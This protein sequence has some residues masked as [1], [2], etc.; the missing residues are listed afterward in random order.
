M[1]IPV[2][3]DNY[4]CIFIHVLIFNV[5]TKWRLV[6]QISTPVC[7][8]DLVNNIFDLTVILV[9]R[10]WQLCI[11]CLFNELVIVCLFVPTAFFSVPYD[12]RACTNT[13]IR[14]TIISAFSHQWE[15]DEEP[16]Y[17]VKAAPVCS[18]GCTGNQHLPFREGQQSL[19]S[20]SMPCFSVCLINFTCWPFFSSVFFFSTSVI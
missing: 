4:N 7:N 11:L 10:H 1:F 20:L 14:M 17:P 19:Q 2:Q 6:H 15:K 18:P 13:G 12:N 16:L 5:D 9:K 3:M 8:S